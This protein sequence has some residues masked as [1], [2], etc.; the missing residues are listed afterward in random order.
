MKDASYYRGLIDGIEMYAWWKDSTQYVGCG[1]MTL[2]DAIKDIGKERETIEECPHSFRLK[3][4]LE[5]K[6][7]SVCIQCGKE[8]FE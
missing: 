7:I 8:I 3:N 6:G 5:V 2:K 1:V 4:E